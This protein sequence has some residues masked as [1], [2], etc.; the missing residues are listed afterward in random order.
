MIDTQEKKT[1]FKTLIRPHPSIREIGAQRKARF[2]AILSIAA[3]IW[4]LTGIISII[5]VQGNLSI[6]LIISASTVIFIIAYVTSRSPYYTWGGIILVSTISLVTLSSLMRGVTDI[7]TTLFSNFPIAFL[8]GSALF[9]TSGLISLVL[10]DIIAISI[11]LVST[12][13]G[14]YIRDILSLSFLGIGIIIVSS[15]YSTTEKERLKETTQTNIKLE[16]LSNKLEEHVEHLAKN[17]LELEE[18]SSHLKAAAKVSQAS[19]SYTDTNKLANEVVDLIRDNFDLYYVGLFL[20]DNAEKW[21]VLRAGTGDAGKRML[22]RGHKIN[23]GEGMIGWAIK[24]KQARIAVDVGADAVQFENP[25]LPETRSEAA[26]PLRSR[27]RVLGALTIQRRKESA[28]PPK[29]VSTLQTMADQI[30]IAFDNAE[31]LTQSKNALE[32]ERRAYGEMSYETW[33]SLT[34]SG[35]I[36]TYSISADGELKTIT[37]KENISNEALK[38]GKDGYS[39]LLPIKIHGKVLGG[40]QLAKDPS[41]GAWQ[42]DELELAETLAEQLSISLESAR[43]FEDSQRR[44]TRERI[45]GETS[46]RIRETLDIERVLETAAIELHKILGEVETEVWLDA[47]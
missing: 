11:V 9:S 23:W 27:G 24:H 33:R 39:A 44:A 31:L 14:D 20:V 26:I 36:P 4:T 13:S 25:D 12:T 38:I 28:F 19:A 10:A 29:I 8:V 34:K 7:T 40:I 15:F 21:A 18:Q 45:V 3:I 1:F 42:Q 47:E 2:S 43:L 16:N 6:V 30:A 32:A 41:R 46:A 17:T 37:G 35:D 22:M 5:A